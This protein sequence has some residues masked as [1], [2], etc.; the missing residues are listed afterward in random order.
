[1][2]VM[3]R[4]PA[5]FLRPSTRR[6]RALGAL[7]FAPANSWLTLRLLVWSATLPVLK[8][9]LPLPTLV[10]LMES[11]RPRTKRGERSEREPTSLIRLIS[12]LAPRPGRCLERSLLLY[13]VLSDYHATVR[14]VIGLRS[15][16]GERTGHAWVLVDGIPY[17]E[18]GSI[19]QEF[20]PLLVFGG[21]DDA[22]A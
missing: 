12:A 9:L 13:R 3:F 10:G 5:P 15:V 6:I 16:G 2:T 7:V 8:Y 20:V 11:G 18:T 14:L 22:I 1:M 19:A 21:D 4:L 17:G